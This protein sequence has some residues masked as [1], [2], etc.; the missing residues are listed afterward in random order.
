[1]LLFPAVWRG[2]FISC[3]HEGASDRLTTLTAGL[4]VDH[5]LDAGSS[6]IGKTLS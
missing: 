5:L 1:M 6:F 2:F 3:S 4:F